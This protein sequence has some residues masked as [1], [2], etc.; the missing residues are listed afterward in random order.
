MHRVN[1]SNCGARRVYLGTALSIALLTVS[2]CEGLDA[3]PM[4][5]PDAPPLW[6]PVAS[7]VSFSPTPQAIGSQTVEIDVER[8]RP[9]S[10][11]RISLGLPDGSNVTAAVTD[12]EE[13]RNDQFIWRGTIEGDVGSVVTLSVVNGKLVG[14]IVTARGKLFSIRFLENGVSLVEE[15][16]P[17]KFPKEEGAHLIDASSEPKRPDAM[18][19]EAKPILDAS[20]H[21]EPRINVMV[22]YTAAA[23]AFQ[24]H[25]DAVTAKI[26]QL[27]SDTR[28]SYEDS[29]V[30]LRIELAY[31]A[32]TDY[33]EKASIGLD[34]QTL[35]DPAGDPHL[36]QV[37]N[38]R[39][40][41][42]A[43]IVVL[44]TKPAL[45]DESCGTS[46]QM[47]KVKGSFCAA[48][49]AVVPITCATSKYSFA[50]ELGHLMGADHNN[51]GGTSSPPFE[52]SRG[53]VSPTNA[54]HTIMAYPT[55]ACV[56]PDCQRILR[57]S[58]PSVSYAEP[59]VASQQVPQPEP[60]G[61][62]A[63]NNALS[64]NETAETVAKFSDECAVQTEPS[65]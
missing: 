29:E 36:G 7:T 5:K 4:R 38:W 3:Q 1:T 22:L 15:L 23:A 11:K 6:R 39:S 46:K 62:D 18:R 48:A 31:A 54:W 52:H 53:Y 26:N 19:V 25:P 21:S 28:K 32:H 56:L 33:D 16:D 43:D 55:D 27:I 24:S 47:T 30:R 60:T 44:L 9:P 40:T 12:F 35:K 41:H 10:N 49:F 13:I 2:A 65:A 42:E 45:A 51:E 20:F 63:A 8:L 37:P 34:W 17:A 14:D 57:W 61:S 58:N 59:S 50:H 64:L